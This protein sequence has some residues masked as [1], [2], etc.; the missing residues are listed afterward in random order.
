[1]FIISLFSLFHILTCFFPKLIAIFFA[2]SIFTRPSFRFVS[3]FN[4][5][6]TFFAVVIIREIQFFDA[7]AY[8][9]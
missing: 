8:A 2:G 5:I 9:W 4:C 3:M 1:M 6:R 7:C